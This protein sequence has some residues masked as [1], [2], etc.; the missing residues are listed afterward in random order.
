MGLIEVR[1][2]VAQR[3]Q[4]YPYPGGTIRRTLT[5]IARR[6]EISMPDDYFDDRNQRSAGPE[7]S[8]SGAG[9]RRPRAGARRGFAAMDQQTQREIASKGGHSQGKE[10]NRGNFWH[11][12]ERARAAGRKGGE[13]HG[14][15]RPRSAGMLPT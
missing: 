3:L 11:D 1:N 8:H 13:A 2:S 6:E 9:E 14:R 12:R 5:D 15:N 4:M 7:P 10:I